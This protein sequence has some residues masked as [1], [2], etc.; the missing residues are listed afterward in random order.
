MNRILLD[1]PQAVAV[2]KIIE[3]TLPTTMRR[4]YEQEF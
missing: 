2:R 4:L 3:P 1:D